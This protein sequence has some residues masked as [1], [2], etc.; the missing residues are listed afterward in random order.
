MSEPEIREG[1]RRLAGVIAGHGP[2]RHRSPGPPPAA[3]GGAGH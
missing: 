3:A 1:I 2:R